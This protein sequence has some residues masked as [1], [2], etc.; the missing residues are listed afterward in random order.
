MY[1]I[2]KTA[3]GCLKTD[4]VLNYWYCEGYI[5]IVLLYITEVTDL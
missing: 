5:G 1:V 4:Q 2:V 3:F